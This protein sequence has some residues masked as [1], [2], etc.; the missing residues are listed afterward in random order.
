MLD[1][2]VDTPD[3]V[4]RQLSKLRE[5]AGLTIE[6]LKR[7][8][9]VMSA[10]GTSDAIEGHARLVGLLDA[11]A[12]RERAAA[13]KADFGLELPELLGKPS[14][15]REQQW[16]GD[17]RTSYGRVIGRDAK[18][19]A[20]W[21]DRTLA[22][23]RTHLLADTFTGDLFVIAA[24]RGERIVGCTLV[25]QELDQGEIVERRSLDYANPSDL[26]SMPCLIY[27]YPRDWR[28][29]S[30]TL[31]VSFLE[32]PYPETIWGVFA[33]SFFDLV[34]SAERSQ[35]QVHDGSATCKFVNPRR[36]QLYAVW[37]QSG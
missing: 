17:R 34:Y 19:L 11:L 9:A 25:Q 23:L 29:A 20:R 24:V 26:P 2:P 5:G 13:L 30:L 10:L 21:S 18:T 36:D 6:R 27:G 31:A 22:E 14:T 28:P 37:W 1:R 16:L 7:S 35:L 8:G 32:Q 12:D 4:L 33:E 3:P 15:G